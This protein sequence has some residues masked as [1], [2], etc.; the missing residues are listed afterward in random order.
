MKKIKTPKGFRPLKPGETV[1]DGCVWIDPVYHLGPTL[2]FTAIEEKQKVCR[3][4]TVP[5][6]IRAK[7][8][9]APANPPTGKLNWRGPGHP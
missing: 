9:F 8:F 3:D 4:G 1:T 5:G 2:A 6:Y 7:R